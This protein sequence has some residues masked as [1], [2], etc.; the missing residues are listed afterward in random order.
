[1]QK[2]LKKMPKKKKRNQEQIEVLCHT[3]AACILLVRYV[4]FTRFLIMEIFYC[5]DIE[6]QQYSSNPNC[7]CY[8]YSRN[9]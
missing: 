5:N 4:I 2:I 7:N 3:T 8:F 9:Y 6:V 1:M